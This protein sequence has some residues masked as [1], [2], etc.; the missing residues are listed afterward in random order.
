VTAALRYEMARLRTIRSTWVL[1]AFA[2]VL[3]GLLAWPVSYGSREESLGLVGWEQILSSVP[4]FLTPLLC[5]IVGVLA[6]GHEYRH[7]TIRPTLTAVPRRMP[8]FL[9]KVITCAVFTVIVAVLAVAVTI[10]VARLVLGSEGSYSLTSGDGM[11]IILGFIAY[12]V[13]N[14]TLALALTALLRN[15]VAA[16]VILL[17]WP[18]VVETIIVVLLQLD[19]FDSIDGIS[20]YLPYQAGGQLYA[21]R[22]QDVGD[23]L[24]GRAGLSPTEGGLV[25][26]AYAGVISIISALG[27]L[28]RD[29]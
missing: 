15:Q 16:I 3:T 17:V 12:C 11:R 14:T 5:S 10:A 13:I 4:S 6:F 27:F 24:L 8:V 28:K 25:F 1:A 18:L 29:A 2:L 26:L 22:L 21:S 23:T 7:G 20:P 19:V 9:A